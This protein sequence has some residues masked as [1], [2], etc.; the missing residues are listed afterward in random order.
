METNHKLGLATGKDLMDPRQYH[1]L[2]GCLICLTLTRPELSYLVHILSQFMKAPKEPHM[3]VAKRV[4]RY[5]KGT[6][7]QGYTVMWT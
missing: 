7:R 1:R 4:L 6:P 2:I 3:E 5:I